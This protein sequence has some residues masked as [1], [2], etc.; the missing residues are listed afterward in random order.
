LLVFLKDDD[1]TAHGISK[2]HVWSYR[3][4]LDTLP[5]TPWLVKYNPPQLEC[6]FIRQVWWQF[7]SLP[8]E[9]KGNQC[10]ILFT[11]DASTVCS[12]RPSVV[13]SQDMLSYEP[14]R[15]RHFGLSLKGLTG[16]TGN[17]YCGLDAFE[18]MAFLLHFMREEDLF[19]DVGANIG[20]YT[21][22]AGN[23][24]GAETIEIEP[25][26][27]ARGHSAACAMSICRIVCPTLPRCNSRYAASS[28]HLWCIAFQYWTHLRHY[29]PILVSMASLIKYQLSIL[30]WEAKEVCFD[31]P[32]HWIL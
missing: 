16:A 30:G 26:T 18:D 11:A 13:L 25:I 22:L 10:D 1:P 20:S 12:F 2:V 9:V 17:W 7:H 14:G 19:V 31:L 3:K 4:L 27:D 8:K 32:V 21:I 6:S 5:D 24:V 15:M 28:L 29:K 23:E